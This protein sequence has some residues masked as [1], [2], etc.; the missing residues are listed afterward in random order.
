MSRFASA[1]QLLGAVALVVAGFSWSVT[2]GLVVLGV[3]L[4]VVGYVLEVGVLHG[5]R[6]P[7]PN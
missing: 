1:L 2:V 7:P 4:F 5:N 3:C 6:Q